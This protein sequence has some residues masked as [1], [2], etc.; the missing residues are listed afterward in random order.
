MSRAKLIQLIHVARR[1]AGLDDETYQA[2]LAAATGKKTCRDMTLPELETA[3][4]AFRDSGFKR[5]TQRSSSRTRSAIVGKIRAVWA[6]MHAAGFIQCGSDA[7]L[8]QYVARMTARQNGG[9]GVARADWLTDALAT[10]VLESLKQ[11]HRRE[12]KAAIIRVREQQAI[13]MVGMKGNQ[14]RLSCSDPLPRDYGQLKR[15]FNS[16]QNWLRGNGQ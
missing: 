10:L 11:W 9:G 4:R 12:L 16:V 3:L 15:L 13:T 1:E 7:A 5:K 8:D 2:K 6:E 14:C